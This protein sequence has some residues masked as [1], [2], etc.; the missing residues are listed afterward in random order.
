[1]ESAEAIRVQKA[2]IAQISSEMNENRKQRDSLCAD[3][4]E[5]SN[6]RREA[7]FFVNDA[8]NS[9]SRFTSDLH[10]ETN[11]EKISELKHDIDA[12][13]GKRNESYARRG[14]RNESSRTLEQLLGKA[15]RMEAELEICKARIQER[16]IG[17]NQRSQKIP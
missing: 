10:K 1:M 4:K 8:D 9:I 5:N 17:G 7:V 11:E 16:I 13:R 14:K 3:L 2:E 6:D 15:R 12:R